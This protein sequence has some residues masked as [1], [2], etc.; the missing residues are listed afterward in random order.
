LV[1][2][3]LTLALLQTLLLLLQPSLPPPSVHQS[4]ALQVLQALL[5]RRQQ[6]HHRRGQRV[7][8]ARQSL[9]RLAFLE[10]AAGGFGGT[11]LVRRSA[12]I[13]VT[14]R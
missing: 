2:P 4:M 8:Q 14:R 9:R 5:R 1:L 6:V 13:R 10:G 11:A 12:G 3:K 7:G